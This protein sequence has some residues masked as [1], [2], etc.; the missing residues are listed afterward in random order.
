MNS[1]EVGKLITSPQERDA[2]HIAVLPV[3]AA[4]QL[5]TGQDIG[6]VY[7]SRTLVKAKD[8]CYGLEAVGIVDPFLPQYY[9]EKGQEFWMFLFPNTVTGMRHHW[10]H[11]LVDNVKP[12]ASESEKWLR[13]FAD[14]WNFDYEEMVEEAPMKEGCVVAR[15]IDIHSAGELDPGE[16]ELF[17]THIEK[18]TGQQFDEQHRQQF[19]WS[20][21]C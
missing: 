15:G 12:P 2:I 18:L 4:E 1:V 20:C 13:E 14:K 17:W 9:V 6:F 19:G 10:Q 11:P 21:S 8:R 16:E 7:G 3:V 5:R